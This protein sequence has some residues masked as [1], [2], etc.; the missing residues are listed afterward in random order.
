MTIDVR[1]AIHPEAVR[2]L[3]TAELREDFLVE[4][5]FAPGEVILT[6]SH[7][8]RLIIGGAMPGAEPLELPTPRILGTGA[9]LERRELGIINIGGPGGVR[10]GQTEHELARRDCLYVGKGAGEIAFASVD[11]SDPA[12]FYLVS[13]PAHASH[14]TV[15]IPVERAKR[16]ELGEQA[17]S[18]RRTIYQYII[19]GL[20]ESS[21]LVMGLTQ[22][23][24]GSMWNTMPC[25]VHDRRSEVYVYFDLAEG[26]RVFHLMGEPSETRHVVM[27]NEQ[28]VFSPGW[29]IHSGVGTSHYAFI[30]A[31]G[32]ENQDYADMDPV[33]MA[34]LR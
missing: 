14:E 30:W 11:A 6:Y 21:Q 9:F 20:C 3:D 18:N 33:A 19:P 7:V 10:V 23:E 17:T 2:R 25:H 12:K 5:V 28:A 16:V 24:P 27:A 22:L 34:D 31:M 29:S 26:A 13:T 4:R 15:R 8:D 32:G 1:Q